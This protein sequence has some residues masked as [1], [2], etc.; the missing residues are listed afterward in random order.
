[1]TALAIALLLA[2][3]ATTRGEAQSLQP[4]TGAPPDILPQVAPL[5]PEELTEP[6]DLL[7]CDVRTVDG[8]N[9]SFTLRYLGR[10]G[11]DDPVKGEADTTEGRVVVVRDASKLFAGYGRWE[12]FQHRFDAYSDS[13]EAAFGPQ[14]RLEIQRTEFDRESVAAAR[15]AILVQAQFGWMPLTKAVGF[16]RVESAAQSPLSEAETREHLSRQ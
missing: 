10:R 9:R 13:K 1:M 8:R 14:L 16:C 15:W 4:P 5:N 3:A 11:Y 12:R 7:D 6:I 2:G